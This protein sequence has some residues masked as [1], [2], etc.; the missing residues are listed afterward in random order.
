MSCSFLIKAAEMNKGLEQLNKMHEKPFRR[1]LGL[2]SGTSL[3]GLDMA[4]CNIEGYGKNTKVRLE[5]FET[6]SYSEEYKED[7]RSV[8]SK[9]QVNLQKLVLLNGLTGNLHAEI[10]LQ[11]LAKWNI[12][13]AEVD[14]IASHGQTIYH[15]PR[16][17]HGMPGYPDATLQIGDG[18]HIAMKTG[19][20]T[21][22]DFRQK[23][24]A[25]GGE[26][27][28]LA[29]YGD[30]ILFSSYEEN[31]VLLNIG[32]ISNF[33]FIPQLGS[34][35]PVICSD[36]GPGNTLIDYLSKKY[37]NV[38]F[39]AEGQ[40][41][42]SGKIIPSLLNVMLQHPFFGEALPKTTGP[43][44]FNFQFLENALNRIE[45]KNYRPEDLI[46]TVSALTIDSVVNTLKNTFGDDS[47]SL[48]VSGGGCHNSFLMN[49]IREKLPDHKVRITEEL[50]ISADAKEAILFALLANETV[51]G[52]ALKTAAGPAVMMGKISL[53]F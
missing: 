29:L 16:R 12:K 26:G 40:L 6:V 24:I 36:T 43:E 30:Y 1:I 3:D 20:I 9:E 27:A 33:T 19:I 48:Y 49:G 23:H 28:P 11:T 51:C 14:C 13:P 53:P 37:F 25:A 8:F 35:K 31:R 21:I 2:M 32:G 52:S 22:S 46:A 34:S 5:R 47:F 42:Q 38:P 45:I 17:L 39:D 15:A 10:I 7:I 44:L 4:L 50:G 18:D 41:A